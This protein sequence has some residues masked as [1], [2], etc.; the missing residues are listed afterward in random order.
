MIMILNGVKRS[1]RRWMGTGERILLLPR[2]LK[3][4]HGKIG[5]GFVLDLV[6][7][8]GGKQM[9]PDQGSPRRQLIYKARTYIP[10]QFSPKRE[11]PLVKDSNKL[12]MCD[13]EMDTAVKRVN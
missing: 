12:G 2:W 8:V 10:E 1:W 9:G 13:I 11:A 4:M 7:L 5:Q 6:T 3:T